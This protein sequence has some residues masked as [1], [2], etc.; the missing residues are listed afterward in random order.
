MIQD[1][2]LKRGIIRAEKI[3]EE[4]LL[5]TND[6]YLRG[7][8]GDYIIH[9]ASPYVLDARLFEHYY[10][11]VCAECKGKHVLSIAGD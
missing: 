8:L 10:A 5:K 9:G 7:Q 11:P 6:K 3:T 1:F 4:I 2:T